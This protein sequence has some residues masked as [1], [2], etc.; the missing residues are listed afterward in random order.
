M[1][2]R[3][4]TTSSSSNDDVHCNSCCIK[5]FCF[6]DRTFESLVEKQNEVLSGTQAACPDQLLS[7]ARLFW[8]VLLP[9]SSVMQ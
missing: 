6:Q 5:L 2:K 4:K 8:N 1:W 9:W 3:W 7:F